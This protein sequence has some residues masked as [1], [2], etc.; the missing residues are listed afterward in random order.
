MMPGR[1]M[2]GFKR[3]ADNTWGL[4]NLALEIDCEKGV[5]IC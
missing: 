1:N 4:A 2:D 5:I 3:V